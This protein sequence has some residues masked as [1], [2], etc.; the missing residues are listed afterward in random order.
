[1]RPR[2]IENAGRGLVLGVTLA[3][4]GYAALVALSRIRYGRPVWRSAADRSPLLDRFIPAPEVVEHHRI[5]IA[6]PASVALA[7]ATEL[8]LLRH[9]VVRAVVKAR[10][11]ALGG[12]PDARPH[13]EA[14]LAQ[15]QSIGWVVLA[16]RR[17]NEIA[18]GAVTQP[19][20]AAPVFRSIPGDD[21]AGF[22]EPGYVKIVWSLRAEPAGEH[23][24]QFHVETRVCTSDP[25]TRERFRRYWSYVAPGVG[26]IRLAM[27]RPLKKEAERRA[28]A[29]TL[30]GART[31]V[32]R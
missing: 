26:L 14:L 17:G 1:M 24:T 10:E 2:I 13:P 29:L 7:A 16:E 28:A 23:A 32:L 5:G 4:V 15:M 18:V 21:F 9:P 12:R 11:L 20:Q 31:T 19:W 3:G 27:L 25:G 22:T 30:D 6:A 8:K